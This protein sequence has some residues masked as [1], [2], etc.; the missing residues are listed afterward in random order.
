MKNEIA[1]HP[2][3]ARQRPAPADWSEDAPM[4]LDEAV[5]VFGSDY[6]MTISTLRTE[7]RKGRLTPVEVAGKF[8]VTP[9]QIKALFQPCPPAPKAPASISARGGSTG[10]LASAFRT[11]TS[12]A[13]DRLNAAQAAARSACQKLKRPSATTSPRNGPQQ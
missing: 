5:A 13:T 2:A 9:S 11:S 10:E 4:R 1:R 7:I 12:S 6:P 8:F 3:R